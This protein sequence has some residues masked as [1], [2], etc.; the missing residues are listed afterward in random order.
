MPQKTVRVVRH[1]SF[2]M[3]QYAQSRL[4]VTLQLRC[5][6]DQSLVRHLSRIEVVPL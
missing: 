1:D 5:I 6:C 3:C 4:Y 2:A